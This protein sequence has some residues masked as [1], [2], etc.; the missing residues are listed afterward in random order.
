MALV[1]EEEVMRVICAYESLVGRSDYEKDLFLTLLL[2]REKRKK[3]S[4]R[5]QREKLS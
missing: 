2:P 3:M 5:W 1:F 4:V